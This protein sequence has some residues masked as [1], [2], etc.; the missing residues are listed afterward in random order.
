MK[1]LSQPA[2][3]FLALAAMLNGCA[4][5]DPHG[6]EVW[7]RMYGVP[8]EKRGEVYGQ[9]L[10][11]GLITPARYQEDYTRWKAGMPR[12]AEEQKEKRDRARALASLTPAQRLNLEMR[13]KELDQRGEQMNAQ[14]AQ[15]ADQQREAKKQA[16]LAAMAG[17][18]NQ[19]A[20]QIRED[21]QRQEDF[22]RALI[23]QGMRNATAQPRTYDSTVTPTYPG[24]PTYVHTEQTGGN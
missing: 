12:W 16:F 3:L 23:L 24:G 14:M 2:I 1:R 18:T 11:E 5:E 6:K 7:M 15:Q 10:K 8:F 17:I 22:N 20:K 4:T 19:A 9:L 21:Q 13:Q